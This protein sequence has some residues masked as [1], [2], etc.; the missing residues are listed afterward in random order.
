MDVLAGQF[1]KRAAFCN[2]SCLPLVA[3]LGGGG[4]FA[5]LIPSIQIK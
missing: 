4:L 3:L 1:A 2:I 5:E